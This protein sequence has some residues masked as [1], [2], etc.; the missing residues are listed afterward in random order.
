[1]STL[2]LTLILSFIIVLVAI[3]SLAIGWLITGKSKIK[4]GM[5]GRTPKGKDNGEN[6]GSNISC[7]LCSRQQDKENE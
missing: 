1:M 5:C 7:D 2:V 3:C 4:G 6:C